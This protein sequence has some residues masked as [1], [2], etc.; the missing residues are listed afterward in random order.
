MGLTLRRLGRLRRLGLSFRRLQRRLVH[1]GCVSQLGYLDSNRWLAS[2]NSCQNR[3]TILLRHPSAS[4]RFISILSLDQARSNGPTVF[5]NLVATSS[6]VCV[7]TCS[8]EYSSPI[9]I[10][11]IVA[12]TVTKTLK[13]LCTT[14]CCAAGIWIALLV[15]RVCYGAVG[16][17]ACCA[18]RMRDGTDKE[19]DSDGEQRDARD[20]R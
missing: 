1:Q 10:P 11:I 19:E 13:V 12:Q 15:A 14:C 2:N 5:A 17:V 6:E 20:G 8:P 4:L 3:N 16:E 7:C 9:L 18:H